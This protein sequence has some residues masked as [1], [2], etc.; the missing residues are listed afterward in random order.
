MRLATFQSAAGPRAAVVAVDDT[1]VPVSDLLAGGPTDMLSLIDGGPQLLE[2]LSAAT[3]SARG[4]T[5]LAQA[6][7]LAPIPRPRRNVMC[8]G[9]N[10]SEHFAEG[11]GFRGSDK[12]EEIP[13]FTTLFSK[14]PNCVVATEDP[15]WHPAPVSDQLDWEAELAV[16]I[17]TGGRDIAEEGA[18]RHV[19]GYTVA[20]DVSVRD[21]Q[22][23]HGNQW[24]K[25]KNFDS[26][27]PMGPWI[28]T[29]DEIPDAQNLALK[30]TVN[31]VVKQDFS[32]KYM[33][34]QIPRIIKEISEGMAL[35]PGDVIITGTPPGVGFARKP[36]EYLKV[37]DVMEVTVEKIGT[38][39]NRVE[40]Y[41][42]S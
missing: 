8:V 32:T 21:V 25:G 20:N 27:L 7:L 28:V 37:G 38:I 16:V 33:V 31:G 39:R 30:L 5:P 35:E 3:S 15:V 12:A 10:Y 4:G 29:A 19:F 23:R 13:P 14:Q 18:L 36:P 6:R 34:Y 42:A 9:W 26:H 17:G 2:R 41:R 1:L 22:R 40:A 24:W 11:Q